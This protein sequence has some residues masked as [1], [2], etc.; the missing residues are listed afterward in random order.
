MYVCVYVCVAFQYA[1]YILSTEGA[2]Y[3]SLDLVFS[4]ELNCDTLFG[5]VA[6]AVLNS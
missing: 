6:W 1:P 4:R 3:S 2:Q 5:D